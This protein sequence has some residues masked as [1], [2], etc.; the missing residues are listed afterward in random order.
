MNADGKQ[1][2]YLSWWLNDF[3]F[4]LIKEQKIL[5]S[6]LLLVLTSFRSCLDLP[7]VSMG[8]VVVGIKVAP[9]GL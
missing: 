3:V 2:Y 8:L 5:R 7:P 9:I 4:L 6:V 1:N